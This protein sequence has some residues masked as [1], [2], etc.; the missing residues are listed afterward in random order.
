MTER[1][2]CGLCLGPIADRY[3][4]QVTDTTYHERCLICSACGIPL[5]GTCF[6]RDSKLYCRIDYDRY[7]NLPIVNQRLGFSGI[8]GFERICNVEV[9]IDGLT[10]GFDKVRD[11]SV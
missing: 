8:N 7:V 11:K 10:A 1:A 5:A 3:I 9:Y 6:A 4:M 2:V